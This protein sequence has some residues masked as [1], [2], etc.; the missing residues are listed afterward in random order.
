MYIDT[1]AHIYTTAFEG[2]YDDIVSRALAAKV[3]KVVLPNIDVPSMEQVFSLSASHPQHCYP[4]VGLHPCS[5]DSDFKKNLDL[6]YPFL[7]RSDVVGVGEIGIDL[8]WDKTFQEEQEIAFRRQIAWALEYDFPIA[9]HSR[10]SLDITIRIVTE[11][12][13]GNLKGI[14]HCFSES[15]DDA[16]KIMDVGFYMGIGGVVTFKNNQ[17]LRDTLKNIP[18]NALL[19]ETDA[20]Y[21][22]PMPYRGKR[23]ESSY[24]PHIAEAIAVSKETT[25]KEVAKT[26][27][28][29]ALTLFRM[30]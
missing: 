8:Y 10:A 27:T 1:H 25:I 30:E 18:L 19:L 3:T 17:A 16:K 9:I 22:T 28:Q 29:N 7:D 24:L 2:E 21:L 13:N 12:Q 15:I 20:P 6:L 26:T 23:N 11:M 5:V 4:M 14:F